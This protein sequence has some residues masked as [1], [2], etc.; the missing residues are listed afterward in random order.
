MLCFSNKVNRHFHCVRP[1]CGYSFV[2]YSSMSLHQAKHL[3]ENSGGMSCGGDTTLDLSE[4]S[5]IV[6]S[7]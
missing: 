7:L 6:I 3:V 1:G 5:Y 2:R 4:Y